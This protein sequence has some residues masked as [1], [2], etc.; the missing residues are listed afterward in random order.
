MDLA[1]FPSEE[2]LH[3]AIHTLS[4]AAQ[5]YSPGA[6]GTQSRTK[7]IACAKDLISRLRNPMDMAD[8]HMANAMEL[9]SI[10]T[11]LHLKALHAIPFPGTATLYSIAD[12]TDA[13]EP[14]LERLLRMLVCTNF[15]SSPAPRV[16]AHTKHSYAYTL[17]PGPGM[18][19]QLV[20]DESFLM[21][22]NLHLYL[23]DKGLHEP[24][25][26]RYSPYAWKSKAEGIPIWE[27]M[28]RHPERL[29]AFQAGLAHADASIPLLGYY[30]FEQLATE[31]EERVVMVDVGGGTG[32]CIAD[33]LDAYPNLMKKAGNFV[34][35]ELPAVLKKADENQRLPKEVMKMEHD[36]WTEQA[37]KGA[38]SYFFRRVLHDYSDSFC[39]T[40]LS[41]IVPAM[42]L[43]SR[44]LI[45]ELMLPEEVTTNDLG[46]ATF[47]ITMFNMG[48]KER[49]EAG[50]K[51]L[52]ESVGCELVKV[53]KSTSGLGV[54]VEGR[55]RAMEEKALDQVVDQVAGREAV[56]EPDLQ[57]AVNDTTGE[58]DVGGS[59]LA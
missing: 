30:D 58:T 34:L 9:V 43:D 47:D 48:G 10:R 25:D 5:S 59:R 38:R 36:F 51:A 21:I 11:C 32:H 1:A 6:D 3:S 22:D 7:L 15:L 33:I 4:V 35:Q 12:S 14:L 41:K 45:A 13:S 46:I 20:Y 57:P 50:F 37:V 18:F 27:T 42:A 24:L 39:T 52:L 19:F 28:A 40:I 54:I 16:Y 26:Q 23:S 2:E 8:V 44:I 49:T 55:L 31:D 29:H 56:R 17:V 53:W